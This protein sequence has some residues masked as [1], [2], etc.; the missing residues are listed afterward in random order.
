MALRSGSI[1]LFSL[2]IVVA[3]VS[4]ALASLAAAQQA[5]EPQYDGT[6]NYAHDLEHGRQIIERAFDQAI[7]KLNPALRRYVRH[8]MQS[9]DPLIRMIVINL[10]G[11]Q[12]SVQYVA[13]KTVTL[14]TRV[15]VP[16]KVK[17]PN[18]NEVDLTQRFEKG[19]LIQHFVGPEG[20]TTN[21]LTLSSDGQK[22]LL[23]STVTGKR[24]DEPISYKLDYHRSGE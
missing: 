12:L 3:G 11:D 23:Q 17:A 7:Q 9:S 18:G 21:V 13:G 2:A 14:K 6:Y 20:D 22:L 8:K 24:L 1:R 16:Q 5:P 19:S 15:G 4:T 10:S